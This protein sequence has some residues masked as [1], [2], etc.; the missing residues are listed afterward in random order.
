MKA[1]KF[2][3]QFFAGIRQFYSQ[4]SLRSV[5]ALFLMINLIFAGQTANAAREASVLAATDPAGSIHI[6]A[7][8]TANFTDSNGNLWL[9]DTGFTA[10]AGGVV[11]R[12]NIA[13][14][15][16]VDDRI[17]Q[18]E[19]WGMTAFAYNVP[20]GSYQV[21]LHF[22]ETYAGITGAG[23]RVFSANVE[24]TA[25]NNIDVYAQA[26]GLNNAL[27]KTANVI[28]TD[29]QLN[30]TFTATANN[31]EINGIVIIPVNVVTNTPGP[32]P[33]ATA[34]SNTPVSTCAQRGIIDAGEYYIQNNEWNSNDPQCIT[35]TGGTAWS[36]TTANFNFAVPGVP[37]TYPSIYKGCHWFN[38][39]ECTPNSGLPLRVNTLTSVKST[40][41]N[42]LPAGNHAYNVAYDLWTH[43]AP[44]SPGQP[45]GTEVMIWI[46]TVGGPVP[47]GPLLGNVNI[48]GY[49]W[50]VYGGNMPSWKVISYQ[51]TAGV[52]SVDNLDVLAIMN[53][54]INRGWMRPTDYLIDA[55]AGYEIFKGGQGLATTLFSFNA[56]SGST[57][58][59]SNTPTKTNTPTATNTLPPS[60]TPT[61]TNTLPPS[62]TPTN[63]ATAT[64][65]ATA[66]NTPVANAIRIEAGGTANFT[67]SNGNL[68]L[69]DT[70][71]TAGAGGVADRG[72]I[73][74]GNTID[75]RIYQTE[76]WGMT[77]FA[78]NVPNGSYQVN[79]HFAETYVGI[80]GPGQRVFSANVEGTA[81]NNID[82][83]AQAG[84]LNNALVKTANVIVTDGQ[85]NIAFAATANNPEINGIEIIPSGPTATP[86]ITATATNTLPPSN[87]P[88][89]TNTPTATNTLPPSNTPTNTATPTNT[90]VVSAVRIEA[91]GA[92]N[93]T[94]SNGN[95]WLADTGFTAGA[96]GV[97]DRGNIA[98]GNTINDR[99]YQTE[100]WGMTAFAYNV[101]N[102]SYQVNLHFAETY[103]GI[104]GAGQ[105][106]FSANVEGTAINNI[107]V[108]A[109]AGGLNNAL[110]KTA[111]V[112]V[113]DGQL[114]ITF[115]A[116]ANNP[117]IN[118]IEIVPS[119][120][121]PT[122]TITQTPG[123]LDPNYRG[124]PF[125]DSV[126]SGGAQ[127]IPGVVQFEYYDLGGEG[128][129]YHD[130]DTANS[131]S[132]GLNPC[133][134]TYLN[135]F[136]NLESADTS[137]TKFGNNPAIDDSQYVLVPQTPNK[138]YLGWTV[139]GEW[140]NYTVNVQ[141]AG[142]YSIN[143]MYTNP[144]GG[145]IS[146]S[147]DG[148]DVSGPITPILTFNAADTLNWRNWHHWNKTNDIARVRLPAGLHVLKLNINLNG[149]FDYAEFT[150]VGP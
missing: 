26:G 125:Q 73:A 99:I 33:T 48:A 149:N 21:N 147:L 1:N 5:F 61:V 114:N 134:G 146:F 89:K 35:Y 11:D 8:G 70:G 62:N 130:T 74:I 121:V 17:Y 13:I 86:T 91:G 122:P 69:A 76:R 92:A 84:G 34:T 120:T 47:F 51:N 16:T 14:G 45:D 10:G 131:G 37:A 87:T 80:T 49:N 4:K 112:I 55:E 132:C 46:N 94:D 118:G 90:P 41:H 24:G 139:N 136:R 145:T 31:P 18:T 141:Q 28:V 126:Y 143:L 148:Q 56:S 23:Q 96:G 105:R 135:T 117:E 25:I 108:Y 2:V 93:F 58:T 30:I 128:V 32:S 85:L 101:P 110:V 129:A 107:D 116:T 88:T 52:A 124:T 75:D 98:I 150:Y 95:L 43:S 142:L 6:E 40:W 54:S 12:G 36:L 109:Q 102:G 42:S 137:Y 68:W 67:D 20:N 53:D 57:V 104:T 27:I 133:D 97:V 50:N 127:Q 64:K 15:N 7:G 138:L 9:A 100:R 66:T 111:N 59:P 65:T 119:G 39:P 79:L 29:G 63:T 71:F 19:R 78:Y 113:T 140:T 123:G 3:L 106:V 44:Y 83:Y 60:N 72:N 144:L 81:I 38:V 77:A 22:A 82:V 103:A 115:A